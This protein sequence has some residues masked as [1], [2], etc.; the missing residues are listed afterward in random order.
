M[1]N[2][3]EKIAGGVIILLFSIGMLIV[4]TVSFAIIII[5]YIYF[6]LLN[7]LEKLLKPNFI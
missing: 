3:L 5:A 1:K 6:T 4:I 2:L 7:L